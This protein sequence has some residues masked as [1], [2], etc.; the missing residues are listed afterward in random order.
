MVVKRAIES[1]MTE[2]QEGACYTHVEILANLNPAVWI[3]QRLLICQLHLE[4]NWPT[5][6][7]PSMAY[8]NSSLALGVFLVE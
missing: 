8:Y 1:L 7:I 2:Y 5:L 4:R 6:K 3:S